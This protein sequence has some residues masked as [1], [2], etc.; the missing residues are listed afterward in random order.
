MIFRMWSSELPM[1]SGPMASWAGQAIFLS[2][3]ITGPG[4]SRSRHCDDLQRL[5]HLGHAD[6]VPAPHVARLRGAHVEL[7][8]LVPAVRHLLAQVPAETGGAQHRA[9]DAQREAAGDVE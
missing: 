1:P 5:P 6:L 7:V 9:G 8:V 3:T 2:A 4:R